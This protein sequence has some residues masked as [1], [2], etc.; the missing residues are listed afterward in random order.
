MINPNSQN[1]S[2]SVPTIPQ[3]PLKPTPKEK[4]GGFWKETF[5]FALLVLFVVV[6]IRF[7]I[8]QPFVVNGAS[9]SPTFTSG[10]Y[11]IV[12]KISYNFQ[13]PT[14]G[15]VVV[16]K[17]P[18][19]PERD[20]IKRII[21][22]PNESIEINGATISIFNESNP[23]GINLDEKYL[24]TKGAYGNSKNILGPEEYFVLGD[25]RSMSS[26]SRTWGSVPEKLII[27]K[28]FLRLYPL[29]NISVFPGKIK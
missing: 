16:F 20:F 12:D 8:A 23:N 7:F 14:R 22:L 19:D 10:D 27:G 18:L 9:M 6:P 3:A 15:D 13:K 1:E 25:N 26:D 5:R 29:H 4:E 21:G 11:I 2:V 28:A 24:E 17:Y